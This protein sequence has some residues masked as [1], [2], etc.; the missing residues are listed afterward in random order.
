MAPPSLLATQARASRSIPEMRSFLRR[1]PMAPRSGR[2]HP[3]GTTSTTDGGAK[4]GTHVPQHQGPSVDPPTRCDDDIGRD[5]RAQR[6][7]GIRGMEDSVEPA[8]GMQLP[9]T[10]RI[11]GPRD[12]RSIALATTSNESGVRRYALSHCP[13]GGMERRPVVMSN[14]ALAPSGRHG[15]FDGS[16]DILRQICDVRDWFRETGS[17]TSP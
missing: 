12:L 11:R 8:S 17:D 16:F 4:G 3:D 5:R 10:S 2:R 1:C 13:S 15:S 9:H 14:S 7:S 6:G